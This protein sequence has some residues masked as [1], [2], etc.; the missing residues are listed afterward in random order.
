M[1][2]HPLA[3]RSKVTMLDVILHPTWYFFRER[4]ATYIQHGTFLENAWPCTLTV[5]VAM[6]SLICLYTVPI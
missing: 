6:R 1:H 5:K 2:G 3:L 4:M